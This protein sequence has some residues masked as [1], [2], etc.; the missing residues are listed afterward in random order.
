MARGTHPQDAREGPRASPAHALTDVE[1]T[2]VLALANSP[3]FRDGSLHQIVPRLADTG[4]FVASEFTIYRLLRDARQLA[5][6]GQAPVRR[7][8]PAH[9]ATGPKQVRSWDIT[10]LQS[11]VRGVFWS[12]YLIM[13]IWSRRIMRLGRP[14]DAE[15]HARGHAVHDGLSRARH[16]AHRS[17][18][19]R[20]YRRDLNLI[21]LPY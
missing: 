4:V 18:P 8:V 5:H 11:S 12:R 2:A 1:R 14:P 20:R 10:Y 7:E 9:D 21:M 15:R 3:T 16:H 6:R 17:R 19:A 13:D